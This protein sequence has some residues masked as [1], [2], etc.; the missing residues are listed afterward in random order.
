[1]ALQSVKFLYSYKVKN[2]E[3]ETKETARTDE[4]LMK[5]LKVKGVE[6]D[7]GD[8]R[9]QVDLVKLASGSRSRIWWCQACKQTWEVKM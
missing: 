3:S 5:K 7:E 9:S 8:E 2:R 6:E 4:S 1:M